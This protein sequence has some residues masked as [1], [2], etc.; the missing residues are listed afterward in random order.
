M[1]G[2]VQ[3]MKNKLALFVGLI[4]CCVVALTVTLQGFFLA[5]TYNSMLGEMLN[6]SE[7]QIV[8]AINENGISGSLYDLT[9]LAA[10]GIC[11]EI[12]DAETLSPLVIV[13]GLGTP[14][15]L[16]TA[17]QHS[18]SEGELVDLRTE[19]ASGNELDFTYAPTSQ[20]QQ[21]IMGRTLN[22]GSLLIISADLDQIDS[23]K[24]VMNR[25]LILIILIVLPITAGIAFLF[26]GYFTAP[27]TR[28]R[29][30]T[31]SV[32]SGNYDIKISTNRTDEL[33]DLAVDFNAMTTELSRTS[34][35]KDELLAN[36]S[37]DLRTPL[38][39]IKGYAETIRDFTGVNEQKRNEQLD[40]I[41]GETDRLTGFVSEVMELS[42]QN[43]GE[44]PMRPET[45]VIN[46]FVQT[47]TV[48][49]RHSATLRGV[50]IELVLQDGEHCAHGDR[51]QLESVLHNLIE[52]AVKHVGE[53]NKVVVNTVIGNDCVRVAVEDH[54]KGISKEDI[55]YIF[56]RY[57]R[58][59]KNRGESGGGL[60][61]AIVKATLL[62]HDYNFGVD[63]VPEVGS[64][65]WFEL[66]TVT[67]ELSPTETVGEA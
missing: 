52:N 19:V 28:L 21:R 17:G 45:F 35:L 39:L 47:V 38:T 24:A 37:H 6:S 61:L 12:S 2:K 31:K 48:R 56:D 42:K 23:A 32:A 49:E 41:I 51:N 26:A 27:V 25:Q 46:E 63:S 43:C 13:E 5:P 20:Q 40:I 59:R 4:C 50:D 10:Q 30:A 53:D 3:G 66:K 22:D 65:F 16:H 9:S 60:G 34:K 57:Y 54:G 55:N 11:I 44:T 67:P 62:R 58:A 18:L 7:R 8:N 29:N 64:T 14:W 33:G 36:I 15:L 1:F